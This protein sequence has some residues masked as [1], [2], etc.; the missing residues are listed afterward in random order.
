MHRFFINKEN[1]NGK[2]II[3]K[4]EDVRHIAN[5]LRL[6]T[7]NKAV[8]CD[9][10]GKDYTVSIINIDKNSVITEILNIEKSVGEIDLDI[11]IY[12]GM[13]KSTK[14]DLVIQK[15][16]ELGA[17]K[18]V[19]I[20]SERT[21]VKLISKNDEIRKINRWQKVAAEAAK[22]SNRGKVPTICMPMSF[23]NAVKDSL[24]KDLTLIPYEGEKITSLKEILSNEKPKNIGIFIGPEGG[25]ADK[26]VQLAIDNKA[27]T[28]TLGKRILRTETAALM[29]LS[30]ILY[31]YNQF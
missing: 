27:K 10:E 15:C 4:G 23:E 9:G 30:C 3:I 29:T 12:Q 2:K 21:V 31:E 11:T 17:N 13:P 28:V 1:I 6:R 20:A 22:Q 16:T 5:V 19:P 18:V 7:G 8:L 26:E 14:M 24:N 25:F